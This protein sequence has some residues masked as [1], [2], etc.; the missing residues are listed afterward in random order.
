MICVALMLTAACDKL[1][2]EQEAE[3]P[4]WRVREDAPKAPTDEKQ[5][6]LP[7]S[8]VPAAEP[9]RPIERAQKK[10]Y[11]PAKGSTNF[12]FNLEALSEL[13]ALAGEIDVPAWSAPGKGEPALMRDDDISTAWQCTPTPDAPCAVGL[14]LP[15]TARLRA[16]RLYGAAGPT[17]REARNEPRI[18]K[19]R[20]HTDEG[21]VDVPLPDDPTHL[22]VVLGQPVNTLNVAV[23]VLETVGKK[24]GSIHLAELEVYGD[25]GQPREPWNIDPARSFV[26]TEPDPWTKASGAWR[27]RSGHIE[28]L[29]DDG[30]VRRLMAGTALVGKAGDRMLLLERIESTLCN[31]HEGTFFLVDQQTRVIAPLG[32]LGGAGADIYRHA[33]G[34]GFG[35]GRNTAAETTLHGV[36]L[37]EGEYR[38]KR[39]AA[40]RDQRAPDTFEAWKLDSDALRRG[41]TTDD[42]PE[43]CVLGSDDRMAELSSALGR[44]TFE[45][46]PGQWVVCDLADGATAY[47]TARA[48]CGSKWELHVLGGDRRAVASREGSGRGT[49]LRLEHPASELLL[50]EIGQS[51]GQAEVFRIT[52]REIASL[53]KGT[54]LALRA[55]SGCRKRCDD[56]LPN[57]HG[58]EP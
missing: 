12:G 26:R 15:R 20:I 42:L 48:P 41:G 18:A 40:R 52:P 58:N 17:L 8:S 43:G 25:E 53:G 9:A 56:P 22:Y 19:V 50:A 29:D 47:L 7:E 39:T 37:E 21:F 49:H 2:G 44:K 46:R 14:H 34:R 16:L 1:G 3:K 6:A 24:N 11:F 36:I 55:P 35:V 38:R 10:L 57:P 51:N 32:A 33:D 13:R 30:T 4:T 31:H 27:L 23:E 28:T 5:D 54:A 45:A